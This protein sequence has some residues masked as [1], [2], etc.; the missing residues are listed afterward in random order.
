MPMCASG[1][2]WGLKSDPNRDTG[3]TTFLKPLYLIGNLPFVFMV[4]SYRQ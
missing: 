2:P 1:R 3:L 4:L